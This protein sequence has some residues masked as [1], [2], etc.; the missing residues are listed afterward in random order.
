MKVRNLI[1]IKNVKKSV[2]AGALALAMVGA[3]I[4]VTANAATG[5]YC[6]VTLNK[7]STGANTITAA[8]T[9]KN[10]SGSAKY[11]SVYVKSGA[12]YTVATTKASASG[13]VN[14]NNTKSCSVGSLKKSN[15]HW[16]TCVIHTGTTSSTPRLESIHTP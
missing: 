11:M 2:I 12:S 10:K 3:A 9:G 5:T 7:T 14:N 4:P 15:N 1:M 13:V 6:N 8:T 16:G